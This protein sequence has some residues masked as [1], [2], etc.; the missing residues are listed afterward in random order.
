VYNNIKT[1][2]N[3]DLNV[4]NNEDNIKFNNKDDNIKKSFIASKSI[5]Y[6]NEIK[7]IDREILE[8]HN[9]IR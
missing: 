7:P 9:A 3:G 8:W 4:I 5:Y 6:T 2:N 1:F